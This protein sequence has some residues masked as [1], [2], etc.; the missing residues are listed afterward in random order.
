MGAPKELKRLKS[1]K[2]GKGLIKLITSLW[3]QRVV[4]KIGDVPRRA[5]T[6]KQRSV[7]LAKT[8]GRCHVCGIELEAKNFHADH[9]KSHISGGQHSENNY[10]PSCGTCNNLRW[11]YSSEEIQV[12]MKLGRWLKSKIVND[13]EEGLLLT[14]EFIKYD[15]ALRKEGKQIKNDLGRCCKGV[16]K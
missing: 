6:K 2:T 7:I 12:I 9:I 3:S 14:K 10:L 1:I 8:D 13:E 16:L 5:L 11:H 4:N 15:M